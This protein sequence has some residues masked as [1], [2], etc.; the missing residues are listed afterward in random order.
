[1]HGYDAALAVGLP[2]IVADRAAQFPGNIINQGL[3]VQLDRIL[4]HPG[5]R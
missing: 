5:E 2:V 4:Q 3:V 1:M